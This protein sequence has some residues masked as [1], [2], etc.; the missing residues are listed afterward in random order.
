VK[1]V[2]RYPLGFLVLA[3]GLVAGWAGQAD[4]DLW[5]FPVFVFGVSAGV[6]LLLGPTIR[7]W[8]AKR[9]ASLIARGLKSSSG[10]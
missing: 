5:K 4:N 1:A 8:K 9:D 2:V 3:V 7:R 10:S 6:D